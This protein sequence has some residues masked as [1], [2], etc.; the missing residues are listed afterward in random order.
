M[1]GGPPLWI[2]PVI[3]WLVIAAL[4]IAAVE[5]V[6]RACRALLQI[7]RLTADL[8]R[9]ERTRVLLRK[10]SARTLTPSEEEELTELAAWVDSESEKHMRSQ[11][12]PKESGR[13][14]V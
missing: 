4:T 14:S 1:I 12:T 10:M 9:V 6:L 2:Y 5:L 8:R 13:S 3:G 7:L 11:L